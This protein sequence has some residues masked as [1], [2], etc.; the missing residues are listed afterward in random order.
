MARP[1]TDEQKQTFL[2]AL[3]KCGVVSDALGAAGISSHSTVRGWRQDPAF[4]EAYRDA[5]ETSAD[6]LES[7]AR[8]RAVEGIE[9]KRYDKEGQLVATEYR[10]SD[11]LLMFLLK[12]N[13]PDKFAERTKNE[14]SSPDGSMTPTADT[15]TAARLVAILDEARRRRDAASDDADPMFE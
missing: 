14:L 9:V 15:Q 10:Y 3:A 11:P 12:G 5:L 1:A 4:D 6:T 13:K 7:E 8:R 2:D